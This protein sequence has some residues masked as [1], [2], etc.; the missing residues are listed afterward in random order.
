MY[1]SVYSANCPH[2]RL[3]VDKLDEGVVRLLDVNLEDLPELLEALVDLGGDHLARDVAHVQGAGRFR[4]K[5]AEIGVPRS[6]ILCILF[7][8]HIRET[9]LLI[10]HSALIM[11]Y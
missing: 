3:D 2:D 10:C 9:K 4:V 5:L 6:E 1:L 8:F 11:I 7:I